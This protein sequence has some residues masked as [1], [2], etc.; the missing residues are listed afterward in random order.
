M[1][2]VGQAGRQ[3]EY[4]NSLERK[5]NEAELT[6]KNQVYHINRLV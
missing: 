6:K 1:Q 2:T 4:A 5:K 3:V